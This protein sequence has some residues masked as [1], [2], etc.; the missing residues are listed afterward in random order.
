MAGAGGLP[1]RIS[2]LAPNLFDGAG[3]DRV[4]AV[5]AAGDCDVVPAAPKVS[6]KQL[7]RI[8]SLTKSSS[9]RRAIP[10]VVVT[11]SSTDHSRS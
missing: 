5:Q 7:A 1:D 6:A 4:V 8:W 9:H 10:T 3:P 2:R 11:S